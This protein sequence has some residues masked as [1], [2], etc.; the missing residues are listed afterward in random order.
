MGLGSELRLGPHSDIPGWE[1]SPQ[2]PRVMPPGTPGRPG[3]EQETQLAQRTPGRALD[4][5]GPESKTAFL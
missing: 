5:S 1:F 2:S 3:G 4:W